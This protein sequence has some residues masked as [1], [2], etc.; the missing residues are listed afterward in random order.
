MCSFAATSTFYCYSIFLLLSFSFCVL[1]VVGWCYIFPL[2]MC[3]LQFFLL[4][5]FSPAINFTHI[6]RLVCRF[7]SFVIR[8]TF[9]ARF[10]RAR[11]NIT[12]LFVYFFFGMMVKYGGE[13]NFSVFFSLV[14]FIFVFAYSFQ[15]F[16]PFYVHFCNIFFFSRR[17][18]CAIV[19]VSFCISTYNIILFSLC[20]QNL[21]PTQSKNFKQFSTLWLLGTALMVLLAYLYIFFL[22]SA[23]FH[24]GVF[25]FTCDDICVYITYYVWKLSGSYEHR[26]FEPP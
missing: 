6:F 25:H 23:V 19:D 11:A 10:G 17:R 16:F 9:W 14:I 1:F 8:F 12:E 2:S 7:S 21:W 3:A 26:V 15:F 20:S 5:S 13:N 4:F 22:G 18:W 24:S